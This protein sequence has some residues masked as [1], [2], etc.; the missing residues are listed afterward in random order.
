MSGSLLR[1][2]SALLLTVVTGGT[3]ARTLCFLPCLVA[4]IPEAASSN[5]CDHDSTQPDTALEAYAGACEGCDVDGID[6]A[7]RLPP[8][9]SVAL[10]IAAPARA[11]AHGSATGISGLLERTA[12]PPPGLTLPVAASLPLRI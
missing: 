3:A 6:S 11:A 4:T 12:D 5:H 1:L 10:W 8:R 2:V 7:D 9:D